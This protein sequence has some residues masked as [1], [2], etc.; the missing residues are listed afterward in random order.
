MND[1]DVCICRHFR[2]DHSTTLARIFIYH[3][4]SA[5]VGDSPRIPSRLTRIF[6]TTLTLTITMSSTHLPPTHL[7]TNENM[8]LVF[9]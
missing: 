2:I 7:V 1:I 3:V 8:K 9:I 6:Q 5:N 4:K